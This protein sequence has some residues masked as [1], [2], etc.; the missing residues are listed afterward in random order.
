MS[1]AR[2]HHATVFDR[3]GKNHRRLDVG[4]DHQIFKA[5]VKEIG[6]QIK[7]SRITG[8]Q[9]LIRFHNA[10]QLDIVI[11]AHPGNKVT[12]GI[13]AEA[14]DRQMYGRL[15]SIRADRIV[16]NHPKQNDAKESLHN[17][18]EHLILI[19]HSQPWIASGELI[20]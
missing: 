16:D 4:F 7:K 9:Y 11:L 20:F 12:H 5:W 18:V 8:H 2:L 14:D 15:G 13:M 10:N 19:S 6:A 3:A 17:L 1:R